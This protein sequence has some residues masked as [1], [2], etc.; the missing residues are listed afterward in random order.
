MGKIRKSQFLNLLSERIASHLTKKVLND[1]K[2]GLELK[3]EDFDTD[4]FLW[5]DAADAARADIEREQGV[6]SWSPLG[7]QEDAKHFV[8]G[9]KGASEKDVDRSA[10][11]WKQAYESFGEQLSAHITQDPEL[12]EF[13]TSSP[14]DFLDCM[15]VA[16][17]KYMMDRHANTPFI[18]SVQQWIIDLD[19]QFDPTDENGEIQLNHIESKIYR[20]LGG[21]EKAYNKSVMKKR[22]QEERERL[23]TMLSEAWDWSHTPE[24]YDN[25]RKNL[26]GLSHEELVEIMVEWEAY[27]VANKSSS[28][29]DA[30]FDAV[31]RAKFESLPHDVLAEAIYGK[32]QEFHTSDNGGH[33]L[34]M[35]P[36]G[37][38]KVS[39]DPAGEEPMDEAGIK[40][41]TAPHSDMV[42]GEH[43]PKQSYDWRVLF[44]NKLNSIIDDSK[45]ILNKSYADAM[46]DARMMIPTVNGAVNVD[47]EEH[48]RDIVYEYHINL[49]ERGSFYADV[50]DEDGK[51]VFEIRDGAEFNDGV[52]IYGDD[53]SI[54]QDGYMKHKNDLIGL[55]KYL[56]QLG[57]I[58]ADSSLVS[59][60]NKQMMKEDLD[61]LNLDGGALS[62]DMSSNPHLSDEVSRGYYV[63]PPTANDPR[64]YVVDE[65][66][67]PV[68]SYDDESQANAGLEQLE[69]E[70]GS[71][72]GT[73]YKENSEERVDRLMREVETLMREYREIVRGSN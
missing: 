8:N 63:V 61:D 41:K 2:R 71:G 19:D 57:I 1:T 64:W 15:A 25:A 3:L 29:M 42:R 67:D 34:W 52:E 23:L 4:E 37:C 69:S 62:D 32:A 73:L 39:V 26:H 21:F 45:I 38:H 11:D 18:S 17:Y 24:A 68:E 58:E 6:D 13:S 66:G 30:D 36:Y 46:K 50:R 44:L 72:Y 60:Y 12:A 9:L 28:V 40:G 59:A 16:M 43:D 55:E 35:C 33:H 5:S 10:G 48:E 53:G 70:L 56:K 31:D 51:T 7:D 20:M 22:L 27:E 14:T 47:I 65:N 54:F 49:D